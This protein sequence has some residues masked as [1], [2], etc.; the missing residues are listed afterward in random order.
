MCSLSASPPGSYSRYFLPCCCRQCLF[1]IPVRLSLRLD[2]LSCIHSNTRNLSSASN[3]YRVAPVD[4]KKKCTGSYTDAIHWSA[5]VGSHSQRAGSMGMR[6][7][8]QGHIGRDKE[9]YWQLS[10]STIFLS[11]KTGIRSAGYWTTHSNHWGTAALASVAHYPIRAP[12]GRVTL[13]GAM[14]S[15]KSVFSVLKVTLF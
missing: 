4:K 14:L 5:P 9:V 1:I 13:Q 8:A 12:E 6:C 15:W 2:L 11:G 3:P 7:L 10:V